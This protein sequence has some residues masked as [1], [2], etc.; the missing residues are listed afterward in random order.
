V[1]PVGSGAWERYVSHI[2]AADNVAGLPP[3]AAPT[4][5]RYL[6]HI[7]AADNVAGLP[8]PGLGGR[9]ERHPQLSG[10]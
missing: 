3:R 6:S 1:T 2:L 8:P 9:P 4:A 7:L 10:T 5:E